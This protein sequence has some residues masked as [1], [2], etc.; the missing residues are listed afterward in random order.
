M[1]LYLICFSFVFHQLYFISAR[2]ALATEA[3]V[4]RCFVKKMFLNV[5]P[6]KLKKH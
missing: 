3:V 1:D 6:C 2:L 5:Q 4:R